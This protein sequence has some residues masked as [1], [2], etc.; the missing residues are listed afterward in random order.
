MAE[1]DNVEARIAKALKMLAI[2]WYEQRWFSI[3]VAVGIVAAVVG[4]FWWV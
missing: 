4:F 3:V 1:M 2:P